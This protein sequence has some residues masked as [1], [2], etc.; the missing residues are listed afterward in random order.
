M[1]GVAILMLAGFG[2]VQWQSELDNNIKAWIRSAL[3]ALGLVL[4][5]LWFLLLSRLSWKVRVGGLILVGLVVLAARQTLKVDGTVDATGLPR[6][7]WKWKTTPVVPAVSPAAVHSNGD[8]G[9]ATSLRSGVMDLA[10]PEGAI[11]VPQ[12]LGPRRTGVLTGSNLSRDWVSTPPKELWRQPIGAGWSAF[13][14]VGGRAFTQ[15]QREEEWVSCYELLTGRLLWAQTNHTRFFEWQGGIGP[16]ATPTVDRDRVFAYGGTGILNCLE[17]S[18]GRRIWSREVLAENELSNLTWGTSS[19]PL[20][21]EHVVIVTG[22][23]APHSTVLAY[24]RESGKPL[25]KAGAENASYASPILAPLSGKPI[26]LSVNAATLTGHDPMT[27][28]ILLQHTWGLDKPPKA[29]QPIVI[30]GDRIFLSA[31]YTMGC[32]ML[33]VKLGGDGKFTV[34][35]LWKNK[36]MKT[37]FNSA[38]VR[39]EFIYGLDDGI[40]ACVEVETGKRRWKDGRYGS[41]QSLIVDDLVLIQS[42]RGPVVLAE[43]NPE[44]FR[45]LGRLPALSGKTWNYPTLAG[46]YL[47]VRNDLEAACYVL[48][49]GAISR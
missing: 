19:S 23:M 11:D 10:A 29:A 46:K 18:T 27:G 31:G 15:E 42:E 44:A 28:A 6:L 40:L 39:G 37:Q 32:V 2:W 1:A 5:L 30:E 33:R 49:V 16:R 48:P 22:G 45:E 3:V 7:V 41:G 38:S 43:A 17:A 20:V 13:A 34:E 12:F 8:P 35:E 47:L 36:M 14:V 9:A 24:D 26:V 25:W 4:T 21:F